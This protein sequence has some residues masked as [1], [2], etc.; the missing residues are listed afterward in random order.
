MHQYV[1]FI[2]G[3]PIR[4]YG[5]FFSLGIIFGCI[6]A[7]YLLKKDGRGWHEHVFDLGITI[8]FVG[9]IGG[10]LW[11]VF[12]FDWDYY[13]NHLLEIPYVW[14]HGHPGGRHL[15]L[16]GCLFLSQK[17][18]DTSPALCGYRDARHHFRTGHRTYRKLHEW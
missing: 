5:I 2:G 12:F 3:F 1:T 11:D 10:R 8:A 14:R 18:Q 15:C 17:T 16:R 7:Y 13:H 9:I 6:M 4:F